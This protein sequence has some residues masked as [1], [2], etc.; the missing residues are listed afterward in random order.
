MAIAKLTSDRFD[1]D[2]MEQALDDYIFSKMGFHIRLEFLPYTYSGQIMGSYLLS[3]DFP[4]VFLITQEGDYQLLRAENH[5]M[6]LNDLLSRYG[7]ELT[8]FCGS[9]AMTSH[10]E[11]DGECYAI[12]CIH[13]RAWSV[14][15]EYRTD[16]AAQYGLD[17]NAVHD[18][19]DLTQVFFSLKEQNPDIIPVLD[20]VWQVWDP[21]G[22]SLGVLMNLG[23]SDTIVNLYETDEYAAICRILG[24]WRQSGYIIDTDYVQL[25]VNSF[26]TLPEVFGKLA[27]Y[28][29]SMQWMDEMEAEEPM[30]SIALSDSVI[31]SNAYFFNMWGIFSGTAYAV[32]SMRFLNALYSDPVI[33]NLLAYGIEH[34]NYEFSDEEKGLI[35]LSGPEGGNNTISWQIR[36]YLVGNQYLCYKWDNYPA[37]IWQQCMDFDR[38]AAL[39][40]GYGFV[41]D[42]NSVSA[43]V[44]ACQ[45]IVNLYSPALLYGLADSDMTLQEFRSALQ[46]A[47]I[48]DII[49]EKQRQFDQWKA[50]KQT[51][52]KEDPIHAS[53]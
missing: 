19:D 44:R 9:Q 45:E 2:K 17:M 24:E 48:D 25:D 50:Q 41:F 33:A 8:S 43:Q 14:G 3:G 46:S 10:V 47:G 40:E 1:P 37:D 11:N 49:K 18:M 22:D 38:N 21:L 51:S 52:E 31:L 42:Q 27:D 15:F 16:I 29:P 5:L 20:A 35:H 53:P 7:Q 32:E 26:V 36:N 13:T 28:N 23:K 12:P 39:S 30:A 4:D 6:P 34:E